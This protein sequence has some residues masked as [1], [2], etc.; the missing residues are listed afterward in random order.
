MASS[1]SKYVLLFVCATVF[2]C[3]EALARPKDKLGPVDY[4]KFREA[5]DGNMPVYFDYVEDGVLKGG[6]ETVELPEIQEFALTM[7]A[8][9]DWNFETIQ[10]GGSP[11]NRIDIVIVGDGYRDSDLATYRSHVN[12]T[13]YGYFLEKPLNTYKWYFNV[14]RVDVISNESGVD[15]PD[16]GIYK[17]TALDMNF[18][19]RL[20]RVNV[21]KAFAAAASAPEVDQIIAFANSILYGGAGYSNL[22]T[23]A[24][25]NGSAVELA[26]HE[27]GHSFGNLADEYAYNKNETYTGPEPGSPN[28]SI[29]DADQ[30]VAMSKKWY[31]WMDLSN[32]YAFEGARYKDFGIYRPTYN[33]KMRSLGRPFDEVNVEQ[34]IFQIYSYVSPI[35]DATSESTYPLPDYSEFYVVPVEPVGHSL[36]VQWSI[37]GVAVPGATGVT[38]R[39]DSVMV[40]DG[41]HSLSVKVVDN[42]SMVRDETK[43]ASLM[44]ETRS[45][46][47]EVVNEDLSEDTWVNWVDFALFASHWLDSDCVDVPACG[48]ADFTGD[49]SVGID[50]LWSFG[51]SWLKYYGALLARVTFDTDMVDSVGNYPVVPQNG[52]AVTN[53]GGNFVIGSGSLELDGVDD[54]VS[55]DDICSVMAGK[56]FTFTAWVKSRSV[57]TQQFIA[58]INTATGVN[59]FLIG[60]QAGNTNLQFYDLGWKNTTASVFDGEWHF[61]AYSLSDSGDR[62]KIYADGE[63]VYNF[64]TTTSVED[65]D[66]F[67]IGQ[68]YDGGL[69]AS[70]FFDGFI[71][72][73]CVYKRVLTLEEIVELGQ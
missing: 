2:V 72:D 58:G 17:D 54:Y 47:F 23:L 40:A 48:G 29:Y 19:G 43:R 73:V 15:E 7:D 35:D 34:I 66:L 10:D 33:S 63:L 6:I 37:D 64:S 55:V 52:A 14:H 24:G 53:E 59:R 62:V 56:D 21:D 38:F 44:S 67:S 5:C 71:D 8:A 51:D 41:I 27:F 16:K 26:L 57:D 46:T 36:D 30:Q 12:T 39:P 65:D 25:G 31:R 68:E 4:I 61:V 32:V 45:W 70:D 42:T 1:I 3:G 18:R 22:A 20:L 49:G 50:D 11:D 13:I 69:A 28:N 9:S 60:H